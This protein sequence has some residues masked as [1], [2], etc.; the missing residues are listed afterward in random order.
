MGSS[1]RAGA[2]N[3]RLVR[4]Q[5]GPRSRETL[6]SAAASSAGP[7][8]RCAAGSSLSKRLTPDILATE[9]VRVTPNG[10]DLWTSP[11]AATV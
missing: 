7:R 11:S 9:R 10:P 2:K 3:P 6:T 4:R 1:L 8:G 5:P